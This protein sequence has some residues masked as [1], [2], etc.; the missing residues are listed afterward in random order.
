MEQGIYTGDARDLIDKIE[1]ES[2]DLILTDPVYDN[3]GMYYW[4]ALEGTRVLKPDTSCIAFSGIGY[5]P[6]VHEAMGKCGLKYRWR[7]ITRPVWAK[8]FH[9]RLCVMTQEAV[10]Y[11]KGRQK[12]RQSVFDCNYSTTKNPYNVNGANWGKSGD[13]IE[14][15]I[16]GMTDPGDTVLDP[17]C[18]S[19]IVPT[20]C[21]LT[22]RRYIAFEIDP[23]SAEQ[24]RKNVAIAQK[25]LLTDFGEE[26]HQMTFEAE[27]DH[28]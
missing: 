18:G 15:Y 8:E 2:I 12:L 13:S 14:Y 24:A 22:N 21:K 27:N 25:P 4:L 3:M 26:A 6:Q 17:F 11:E 19:G 10:W 28:K 16:L 7:L 9:G 20:I 23:E 1:D 5:L